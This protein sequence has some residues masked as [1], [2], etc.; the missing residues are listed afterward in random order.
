MEL[1][2]L[3][4]ARRIA[5]ELH[6][7]RRFFGTEPT[8]PVTRA[9]NA[10]MLRMLPAHGV[11]AIEI[12]RVAAAGAP[13]SASR[14]RGALRAGDAAGLAALVPASTLRFLLSDEARA[15]RERLARGEERHGPV[16]ERA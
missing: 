14:V 15:V 11:E 1:D 6:V 7:V 4:F 8:C 2:L 3:L 16:E 12:P 10:A 5:P 9:Y 13:I